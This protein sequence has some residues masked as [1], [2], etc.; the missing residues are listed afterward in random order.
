MTEP[1]RA[2]PHLPSTPTRPSQ[3]RARCVTSEHLTLLILPSIL[4]PSFNPIM[5]E[6]LI[7]WDGNVEELLELCLGGDDGGGII[8]FLELVPE[9][10]GSGVL[11]MHLLGHINDN[12]LPSWNR[13]DKGSQGEWWSSTRFH[14][15]GRWGW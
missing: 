9:L 7:L 6:M 8:H 2:L 11:V 13:Y 14:L 4:V 15:H 1:L 3:T 5:I 12:L 10:L